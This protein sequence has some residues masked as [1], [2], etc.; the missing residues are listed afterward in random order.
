MA[1]SLSG[2]IWQYFVKLF[3][4]E[5]KRPHNAVHYNTICNSKRNTGNN[6]YGLQLENGWIKYGI[7][8]KWSTK[9]LQ[10]NEDYLYILL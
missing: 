2:K 10:R 9:L 4:Q 1:S 8:T 7:Y 3:D 5:K 6:P